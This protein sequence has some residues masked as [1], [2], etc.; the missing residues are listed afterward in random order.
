M[1]SATE[2]QIGVIYRAKDA[3]ASK[4]IG[5]IAKAADIA[6]RSLSGLTSTAKLAVAGLAGFAAFRLAKSAFID[7]NNGVEMS[8][9]SL[10]AQEKM[11]L[12]GPWATAMGHATQL[13]ADY[14]KVAANSVGE[15]RDFVDMHKGI[16]SSAYRA[17]LGMQEL[18]DMT[19]GATIA[20]TALGERADMVALDIKQMLSGDVTSRDRTAQILLASQGVTQKA[21]NAMSQKQRNAIVKNSLNDPA[22]KAAAKAYG[23]S[24]AGVTST[25]KDNL[26][27]LAGKVG[28]P[29][30]KRITEEVRKWNEWIERNPR[31]IQEFADTFR[32]AL[33][34][35]FEVVKS[36][37][38]FITE[39][40]DLL[41]K[42]AEAA[43]VGKVVGGIASPILGVAG[44]LN[45]AAGAA[46]G[47]TQFATALAGSTA[48]L[49]ALGVAVTGAATW[50]AAKTLADGVD[51]GQGRNIDRET[52]MAV[53]RQNQD[54][55]ARGA[56]IDQPRTGRALLRAARDA[57]IVKGAWGLD[58]Q[59]VYQQMYG[60]SPRDA[61]LA[62]TDEG[63]ALIRDLTRAI[64][65]SI[66]VWQQ[67][68]LVDHYKPLAKYL[69]GIIGG[70][71]EQLVAAWRAPLDK[72]NDAAKTIK[73]EVNQKI[74][75]TVMS[76]D[77]DR[78][79]VALAKLGTRTLRN[80]GSARSV[81]RESR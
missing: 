53:V 30:F 4:E 62:R 54:R 79:A 23:E 59:A 34:S 52:T 17:G 22:L 31:K 55:Y 49:G 1:P 41:L 43:L 46:G 28:L 60:L 6:K 77:P 58:R 20:A 45:G 64:D 76:D 61:A 29:L 47:L 9:I 44:A 75:V 65:Q 50:Y 8:T 72:S 67:T 33:V 21:F 10:A 15:T 25:L 48:A 5:G 73:P 7:F 3:G 57:G 81:I 74:E 80:P 2:Y 18:K 16:A 36:V 40:K 24:F 13:F 78:F 19:I 71:P 14:Q 32:G 12:G 26:S 68:S 70:I 56:D 42:L 51:Q 37:M 66:A 11:L 63:E 27:I 39:H 38:G 35:G 69:G